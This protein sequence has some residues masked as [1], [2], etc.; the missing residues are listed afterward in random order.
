VVYLVGAG[1]GDPGLLTLRGRECLEQAEVI[2]VDQL[3]NPA[4]V[5]RWARPDAEVIVRPPRR[6]L[7]QAAINEM[8]VERARAGKIVVRLK[9]GDPFLFGRGGEEAEALAQ[10]G[11]AFEVVPG[12]SAAVA[13]PAYAGIPLT[14]RGAAGAIAFATAHEADEK[15]GGSVGWEALAGAGTLVLFMGV[16]HLRD[17]MKRLSPELPVAVIEQGTTP[18]QRTIVG[19]VADIADLSMAAHL[20]PPALVVVGEVVKLR[21]R[22]SW[23]ERRRLHGRRLLLLSTKGELPPRTDGLEV[24]VSSPLTVVPR[25]SD[26]KSSLSRPARVLAFTSEHA[27]DVLLGALTSTGQDARAL[28][29]MKLAA[30]GVATAAR[31]AEHHLIAD[32]VGDGTGADLAKEIHASGFAGPVRV[33]GAHQGRP[34]LADTLRTLGYE[35]DSVAAYETLPDAEAI[36]RAVAEH[37]TRPFDAIAFASPKGARAFLDAIRPGEGTQPGTK[38]GAIGETTRAC[39]EALGLAVDAVPAEPSLAALVDALAGKIE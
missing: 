24:L 11:I 7:D 19:T 21:E 12:V 13:V 25:F 36:G 38:I 26:V 30:V 14:H 32:L 4:L 2:L 8:L 9:G 18:R 37:R 17:A 22:L 3:V 15:N 35:V 28:F 23:F 20:K 29:G 33:L 1:P 34:E 31:L 39:L 6:E 27:V 5:L 16:K 10:A